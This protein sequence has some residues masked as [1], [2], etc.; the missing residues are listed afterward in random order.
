MS[1]LSKVRYIV[2]LLILALSVIPAH[3]RADGEGPCPPGNC[4]NCGAGQFCWISYYSN[5]ASWQGC[6]FESLCS[7]DG[8]NYTLCSCKPCPD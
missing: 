1:V 6:T 2:S 4:S 8:G 7:K 3:L 5:C